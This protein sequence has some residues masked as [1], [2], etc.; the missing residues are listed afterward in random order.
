MSRREYSKVTIIGTGITAF[1]LAKHLSNYDSIN[2]YTSSAVMSTS[3]LLNEFQKMKEYVDLPISSLERL[4]IL[5][6]SFQHPHTSVS[7]TPLSTLS[8]P[9]ISSLIARKYGSDKLPLVLET[10]NKYRFAEPKEDL[11]VHYSLLSVYS[12]FKLTRIS[13]IC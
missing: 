5:F 12:W 13:T 2:V 7:P 6:T 10:K 4:I 9:Y 3:N 11:L 8:S 1:F